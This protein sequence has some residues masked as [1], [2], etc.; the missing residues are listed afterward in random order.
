MYG[1]NVSLVVSVISGCNF[2]SLVKHLLALETARKDSQ[3]VSI[4]LTGKQGQM[5][6]MN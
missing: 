1:I 6:D 5:A 3:N 4:L 2:K